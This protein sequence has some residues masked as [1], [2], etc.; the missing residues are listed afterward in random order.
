M[1][2]GSKV[3]GLLLLSVVA[4]VLFVLLTLDAESGPAELGDPVTVVVPEAATAQDVADILEREGV[5]SNARVFSFALSG[6]DRATRLQP[7]TFELREGM[8]TDEILDVLTT[9]DSAPGF[10]V[11]IPEGLTVDG[12]IEAIAS[13]EDSPY[14]VD[15]LREAL[16]GVALPAWVPLELPDAAEPFEGLLA[17]DTYEFRVDTP[18]QEVLGEL[19]SLTEQRLTELGIDEDAFYDTL[20]IASLIEREVRVPE[21]RP[22]VSSVIA[23]RLEAERAL[24]LDASTL[25]ATALEGEE[26]LDTDVESP[27]NTYQTTGLP[28]TPIAAPGVAALEAAAEPADTEFVYYVVCDTATGEHAFTT[29]LDAHNAN[30]QR[31]FAIRDDGGRFCDEAA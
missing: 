3:F 16:A 31:Y 24:Q 19:V 28:P 11:T 21:E 20:T 23:N 30:R 12:T 9:S 6:D 2:I 8:G 14:A 5:I 17:P 7:G 1:S 25:Y 22:L 29:S 27:W 13:A 10:A 18:A 26:V 4:G 15:E